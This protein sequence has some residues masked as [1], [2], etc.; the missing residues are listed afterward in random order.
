[1]G[2]P[3]ETLGYYFYNREEG[4][5]FVPRNGVFLEKEFL[6]RGVSM[7]TVQ[8]EEIREK[9]ARGDSGKALE[10]EPVVV[11]MPVT[12]PEPRRYAR[13][14]SALKYKNEQIRD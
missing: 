13:L 14:Q 6:S 5:V 11:P 2:H 8:L 1:V 9:P 12:T 7:S 3:R 10:A 4:K